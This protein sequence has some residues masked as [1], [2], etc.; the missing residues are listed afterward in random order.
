MYLGMVDC[1]TTLASNGFKFISVY[2]KWF[3]KGWIDNFYHLCQTQGI[4]DAYRDISKFLDH[5]VDGG[6]KE[7][8]DILSHFNTDI[9]IISSSEFDSIIWSLLAHKAGIKS[10]SLYSVLGGAETFTHPPIH[11]NLIKDGK[12]ISSYRIAFSWLRHYWLQQLTLAYITW[13]RIDYLP[14]KKIYILAKYCSYPQKDIVF[15]TDM[16]SPQLKLPQLVL[17]PKE[18]DFPGVKRKNR[19]YGDSSLDLVRKQE[20]FP[21]QKLRNETPLIYTALSTLPLLKDEQS[22]IFFQA[23]IDASTKWPEWDWVIS[24]GKT[25]NPNDFSGFASN[26]IIVN[27]APQI[28]LLK[29]ATLMITH[30]GPSSIKECIYFAVP[31]IAFPLWFDQPGNVARLVFHKLGVEGKFDAIT[32][33]YMQNLILN[34][35]N[36][37]DFK[38]NLK[39]MQNIFLNKESDNLSAKIIEHILSRH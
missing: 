10:V 31:M 2:E 20:D 39:R 16:P 24:I 11:T 25:L 12:I 33:E 3:P 4:P 36:N 27:R 15:F 30:G 26:V 21:W 9:L 1:E 8:L 38:E 23:I 29:K 13:K 22:K 19:H 17:F 14:H 6:D 28:D 32:K 18:F 5:L 37:K 35:T 7:L 34:V